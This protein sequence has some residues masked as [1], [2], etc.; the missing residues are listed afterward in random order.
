MY[1]MLDLQTLTTRGK[2]KS[3]KVGRGTSSGHGKTSGRGNK[4]Q[5]SRA[6]GTKG[7]HF[8]GGQTPLYRR[9]PKK[10]GFNNFFR[11]EY[12][13]INLSD[14]DKN[15][16]GTVGIVD[17]EKAGLIKSGEKIK[18][19]GM[20]KLTK[21]IDVTAHAFSKSAIKAIEAAQGKATKC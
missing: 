13:V 5:K 15:F 21:A 9:L 20:G 6:G 14:L 3:K 2:T 19:L 4:G 16:K 7:K 18:V 11:V 17:F 12:S 10:R 8:E 1:K